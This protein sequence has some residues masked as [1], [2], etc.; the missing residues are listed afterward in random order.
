MKPVCSVRLENRVVS[1]VWLTLLMFVHGIGKPGAVIGVEG[2]PLLELQGKPRAV[3]GYVEEVVA[4]DP[5]TKERRK[6]STESAV[7]QYYGK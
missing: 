5:L 7:S 4:T 3:M 6:K 1:I 2:H